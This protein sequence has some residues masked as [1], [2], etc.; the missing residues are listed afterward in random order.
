MDS[1]ELEIHG[2]YWWA[3]GLGSV[4]LVRGGTMCPTDQYIM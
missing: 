1:K 4:L 2:V 3:A